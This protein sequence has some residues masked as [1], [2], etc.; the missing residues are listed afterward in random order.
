MRA[1]LPAMYVYVRPGTI[2]T[3][4][5]T[6]L[7]ADKL[8]E[9][10]KSCITKLII[11]PFHNGNHQGRR[12]LSSADHRLKLTCI[13]DMQ[14][15]NN[16]DGMIIWLTKAVVSLE[17]IG[18][19]SQLCNI[20]SRKQEFWGTL[21]NNLNNLLSEFLGSVQIAEI[22]WESRH[23]TNVLHFKCKPWFS[24]RGPNSM[25]HSFN[26]KYKSNYVQ[27]WEKGKGW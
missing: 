8:G 14:L 1:W 12:P 16:T 3:T 11:S 23:E 27:R 2:S 25:Y 13:S 22:Q 10:G 5:T 9:C 20:G 17:D 21:E 6:S 24:C 18:R 26:S 7:T 19:Y 15:A 4:E